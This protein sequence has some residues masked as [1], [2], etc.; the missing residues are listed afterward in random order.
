MHWAR[1]R[2]SL[3]TYRRGPINLVY[4]GVSGFPFGT[5][6]IQKM[7]LVAKALSCAEVRV[8]V[9]CSR[10]FHR[11]GK[12]PPIRKHGRFEGTE[13]IYTPGTPYRDARFTVRNYRKIQGV[14]NEICLLFRL[15]TIGRLD[16]AIVAS[17]SFPAFLG[18]YVLSRIVGFKIISD[19]AEYLSG[20]PA[21][22]KWSERL[23]DYLRD[24]VMIRMADG[25]IPI[26]HFLEQHV[27]Q[28]APETPLIRVPVLVDVSR[29]ADQKPANSE[30]YFLF[31]S[32][33]SYLE[34]MEF[35]LSAFDDLSF[36][37][38]QV[39]LY[40]V[41][42]GRPE[43]FT[44]V[45]RSIARCRNNA[46]VRVLHDLT[47]TELTALYAGARALLIPLRDTTQDMARFPHKI[48][49]YLATGN[50]VITTRFGE[51]ARYLTDGVNAIMTHGH[52]TRE[53][54]DKM[55]WVINNPGLSRQIGFEGQRV[56]RA[57]FDYRNHS[58][59]LVEFLRGVVSTSE[60][61]K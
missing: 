41:L 16:V 3:S 13:Y 27:R 17:G 12:V 19:Y 61:K 48:G 36:P 35:I 9:I 10:A 56:A 14:L 8:I 30:C 29:F 32:S 50:P 60:Q 4:L 11:E 21:R 25:I 31:C 42:S 43:Q 51:V 7:R 20:F 54:A 47:D 23:N 15:S 18:Y 37:D 40:L 22:H 58:R 59:R 28:L 5:A 6:P 39:F 33:L 34:V 44:A 26:S 52:S 2:H 49:E 1:K 53:Y 45:N 46:R 55:K 38:E 24:H 57:Q